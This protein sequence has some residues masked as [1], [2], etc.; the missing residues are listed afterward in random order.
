MFLKSVSLAFQ[1]AVDTEDELIGP[2]LQVNRPRFDPE[3][4]PARRRYLNRRV[5]LVQTLLRWRKHFGKGSGIEGL[6]KRVVDV[7]IVP[8]ADG[9][10]ELGGEECLRKV[11]LHTLLRSRPLTSNLT[12]RA[13]QVMEMLSPELVTPALRSRLNR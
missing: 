4:I 13:S 11:R 1:A 5:K 8:V 6:V 12:R 3:A 2:Y 9:G 7:V 10:W